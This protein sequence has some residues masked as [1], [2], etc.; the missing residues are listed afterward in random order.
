[1]KKILILLLLFLIQTAPVYAA[2]NISVADFILYAKKI[3][4]E[5]KRIAAYEFKRTFNKQLNL[6]ESTLSLSI[7]GQQLLNNEENSGTISMSKIFRE[8]GTELDGELL[9]EKNEDPSYRVKITQ[10][11][12]ANKFGDL[13][14][15]SEKIQDISDELISLEMKELYEDHLASLINIYYETYLK[16]INVE[17]TRRVAED[18]KLLMT[19]I[20][21][22]YNAK[23]ATLK[24]VNRLK[25]QLIEDRASYDKAILEYNNIKKQIEVELGVS[26][27]FIPI[28]NAPDKFVTQNIRQLVMNSRT[29]SIDMLSGEQAK[30]NVNLYEAERL[31]ELNIYAQKEEE[32]SQV[33][34]EYSM[35]IGSEKDKAL[36]ESA[37]WTLNDTLMAN[38]IEKKSLLTTLYYL[39]EQMLYLDKQITNNKQMMEL[40]A[41]IVNEEQ[42]DYNIGRIDLEQLVSS[43][44]KKNNYEKN[45]YVS[46]VNRCNAYTEWLRLTD[47]IVK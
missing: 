42:Q 24:D 37:K 27:N 31:P 36:V 15:K 46:L 26:T 43:I 7:K 11:L 10:S 20:K 35:K 8:T 47:N 39:S 19:N 44:N 3:N 45:Y 41:Q 38:N 2:E 18:S 22:R 40:Y 29:V 1:M 17:S 16:Y 6:D 28:V 23:I 25:V 32:D 13:Y 5:L 12:I 21:K 34:F 14:K 30:I 33:G 4:M 9:F